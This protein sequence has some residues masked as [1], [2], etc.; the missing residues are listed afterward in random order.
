MENINSHDDNEQQT[1]DVLHNSVEPAVERQLSDTQSDDDTD[2]DSS[3]EDVNN[4]KINRDHSDYC[5]VLSVDND[6][7]ETALNKEKY[8]NPVT[9][10]QKLLN[11]YIDEIDLTRAQDFSQ[12]LMYHIQFAFN[13]AIPRNAKIENKHITNFYHRVT[14][15]IQTSTYRTLVEK[16]YQADD[17]ISSHYRVAF[18]IVKVVRKE[19]IGRA[20]DPILQ[21]SLKKCSQIAAD[22]LKGSTGGRGKLRYLGGWVIAKLKHKKKKFVR[23]NLYKQ[24]M[25]AAADKYDKEVRLLETLTDTE[26]S[27]LDSSTDQESLIYTKQK[28]NLRGGLTNISDECFDFFVCLDIQ[29]QQLMT[30]LAVNIYGKNFHSYLCDSIKSSGFLFSEFKKSIKLSITEEMVKGAFSEVVE[31]YMMIVTAQFRRDYLRKLNVVKQE[32]HRKEIRL[33]SSKSTMKSCQGNKTASRKRPADNQNTLPSKKQLPN[34]PEQAAPS[35]WWPCGMCGLNCIENCVCCD[36]CD[37]WHH[38]TCLKCNGDEFEDEWF[39]PACRSV[40]QVLG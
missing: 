2:T 5:Q 11:R 16:L 39:C 25:K 31:K 29:L 24:N 28:Q 4:N 32:A 38:Y 36:L 26:S 33:G 20:Y 34:Q 27:L 10:N 6:K 19:V 1:V 7:I 8:E 9:E 37:K 30:E 17:L 22:V 23:Q 15:F 14:L 12:S 40:E 35:Q 13:A 21:E 3:D 18:T